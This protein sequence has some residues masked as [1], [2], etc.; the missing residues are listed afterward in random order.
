MPMTTTTVALHPRS[1]APL[2]ETI[3]TPHVGAYVTTSAHWQTLHQHHFAAPTRMGD[4]SCLACGAAAWSPSWVRAGVYGEG[5][6]EWLALTIR[7]YEEMTLAVVADLRGDSPAAVA[8]R[9][10][11]DNVGAVRP[12]H[13]RES[14]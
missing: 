5:T 11:A 14:R 4:S 13:P 7:G 9:P 1:D 10:L 6:R 12:V 3:K 8:H 2:H